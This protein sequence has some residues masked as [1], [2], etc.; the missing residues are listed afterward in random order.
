MPVHKPVK[1]NPKSASKRR[2]EA[3]DQPV[4]GGANMFNCILSIFHRLILADVCWQASGDQLQ[5]CHPKEGGG[6]GSTSRGRTWRRGPPSLTKQ[7]PL[8]CKINCSLFSPFPFPFS[9][10]TEVHW[11][12]HRRAGVQAQG[13]YDSRNAGEEILTA[14]AVLAWSD[15]WQLITIN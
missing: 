7:L 6:E 9:P 10:G 11:G 12:V 8:L 3:R 2:K 5:E 15:F 13:Q 1:T 4:G 14:V